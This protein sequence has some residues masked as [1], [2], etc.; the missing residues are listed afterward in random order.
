MFSFLNVHKKINK[1]LKTAFQNHP[2]RVGV[3]ISI[4]K[5]GSNS[6]RKVLDIGKNRD[7]DNTNSKFIHENH[8]RG[9]VLK[10]RYDLENLFVFCFSRNPYD[11]TESW[12]RYHKNLC[13]KPY[14]ELSFRDWIMEG[15]PHH[16]HQQNLTNWSREGLTPLL[17]YNFVE[18]C[19][20][21]FT[22]R[23]E[24]FENDIALLI[25]KLNEMCLKAG[26]MPDFKNTNLN[27]HL[28]VSENN[29][30]NSFTPELIENVYSLL[31]KDFDYFGYS[32]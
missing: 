15:M 11:R 4:P 14:T 18:G 3:F 19:N 20:I 13:L 17:Q 9:V 32:K 8:Q 31:K 16:F 5:N 24:N 12:Y 23:I 7:L 10:E 30:T 28:N 22:G 29:K 25:D 6:I 27:V 2:K 1:L 21:D 26:E